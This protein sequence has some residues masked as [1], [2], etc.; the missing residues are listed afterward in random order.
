MNILDEI[1]KTLKSNFDLLDNE[2][3]KKNLLNALPF[4]IG[5][6][7]SG[8]IAVLYA[9]L[10]SWAELGT[11]LIYEKADWTFLHY[12]PNL[13]CFRLVARYEICTLLQEV[14]VF[15]K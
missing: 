6:F 1:R 8:A 13:F 9:K 4:W 14:V 12:Y 2:K 11:H 15:H 7:I 10:F 5:A 3:L